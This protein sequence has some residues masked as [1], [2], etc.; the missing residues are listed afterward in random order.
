MRKQWME[1]QGSQVEQAR[2]RADAMIRTAKEDLAKQAAESRQGLAAQAE[3][4]ADQI[5]NGILR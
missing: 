3:L 5:A 1:D 4:L 2:A